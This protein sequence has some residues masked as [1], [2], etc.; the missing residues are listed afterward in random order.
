M[1]M[2]TTLTWVALED[3]NRRN[4]GAG[5]VTTKQAQWWLLDW[6]GIMHGGLV[7]DIRPYSYNPGLYVTCRYARPQ[8]RHRRYEILSSRNHRMWKDGYLLCGGIY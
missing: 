4:I 7:V 1:P 2:W 5:E 6:R 8:T 3:G